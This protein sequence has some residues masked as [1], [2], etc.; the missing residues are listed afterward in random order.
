MSGGLNV[1]EAE[2]DLCRLLPQVKCLTLKSHPRYFVRIGK[3]TSRDVSRGCKQL[4]RP[5]IGV[6]EMLAVRSFG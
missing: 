2:S 5:L 3:K 1:C 4:R 6:W